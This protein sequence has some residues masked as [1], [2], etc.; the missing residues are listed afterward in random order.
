MKNKMGSKITYWCLVGVIIVAVVALIL[1]NN[2]MSRELSSSTC[3]TIEELMGQKKLTFQSQLEGEARAISILS[4]VAEELRLYEKPE[5]EIIPFLQQAKKDANFQHVSFCYVDGSAVSSNG[6][7]MNVASREYFQAGLSG[8]STITDPLVSVVDGSTIIIFATPVYDGGKVAAVLV[9]TYETAELSRLFF[10]SYNGHGYA[11][12]CD[13]G[14]EVIT[15]ASRQTNGVQSNILEYLSD[16]ETLK[17]DTYNIVVSKMKTGLSGHAVYKKNGD[18]RL[19]HYAPL[20]LNGWYI[21]MTVSDDIISAEGNFIMLL[22][23]ILTACIMAIFVGLIA[24][25][26]MSQ[27]KYS[28]MLYKK[29]Y[30]NDLT[31]SPNILKFREDSNRLLKE[32]PNKQY[33]AMRISIEGLNFLNEIFGFATGDKI[34]QAVAQTFKEICNDSEECFAH[35]YGDRFVALLACDNVEELDAQQTEFERI[36]NEKIAG[37]VNYKVKFAVGLYLVEPEEND[38]YS[39]L[40]KVSF[41]HHAAKQNNRLEDKTQWYDS[42]L[43]EEMNLEREVEVKMEKALADREFTMFLQPKYALDSDTLEGAEALARWWING[44]YVMYP[45]DFIPIF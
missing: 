1:Y 43:K 27:R 2:V 30:Y 20:D 15:R 10:A 32:N 22:T 6:D 44:R 31:D 7:R 38:I 17:H 28:L 23:V 34:I 11:Y 18:K 9:G 24:F 14:G 40:E 42:K 19:L 4:N 41:A 21:F 5:N 25:L 37:L 29:A 3:Q 39:V 35:I 36:F 12:I 45:A 16:T 8:K 26:V 33:A 13:S